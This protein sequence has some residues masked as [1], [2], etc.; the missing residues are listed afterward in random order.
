MS[1]LLLAVCCALALSACSRPEKPETERPPAPQANATLPDAETWDDASKRE[2][3]ATELTQAIQKPLDRARSVEA[4]TLEA[5]DQQRA[6]IDA[7]EQ[8][9]ATPPPSDQ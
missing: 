9:N 5:A 3:P 2:K 6:A 4:T 8:G 1:R 7:Q